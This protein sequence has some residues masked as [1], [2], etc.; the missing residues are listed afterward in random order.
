LTIQ[1]AIWKPNTG[2]LP[3]LLVSFAYGCLTFGLVCIGWVLF[4]AESVGDAYVYLLRSVTEFAIPD[5]NRS[6]V[7]YVFAA[8]L[9]D[10]IWRSDTR[11]ESVEFFG[12]KAS[13]AVMFRWSTYVVMF[14]TVIVATANRSG[15]QQFIYFQF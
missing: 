8:L 9:L 1:N 10:F 13:P 12:L 11:L 14:W 2:G 6:G 7:I 5:T 3:K 15:I 4:R